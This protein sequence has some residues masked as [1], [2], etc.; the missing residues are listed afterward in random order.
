MKYLITIIAA[1]VLAMNTSGSPIHTAAKRGDIAVVKF[2]LENGENINAKDTDNWTPLHIAVRFINQ[3]LVE[4][5]IANDANVNA[6]GG[7]QEGAPLHWA[8]SAGHI[9][10][11][12]LLIFNGANVNAKAKNGGTPLD[13]ARVED[14]QQIADFLY[15]QGGKTEKQLKETIVKLL[16]NKDRS[17]IDMPLSF[18][19]YS[20]D[21]V[22][23]TIEVTVDFRKWSKLDTI[24]G[25][26][27]VVKFTDSRED[28]Y[29]RQFYRVK[30]STA[31]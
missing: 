22:S 18:S 23:Y 29:E 21:G 11:V 3:E 1:A 9:K 24:K 19:F 15:K 6:K 26:D 14:Q 25:I 13:W 28:L 16:F 27:A 12:E 2:E 17:S 20:K 31:N 30:I 8:S 7:W 5:L 4:F 10:I